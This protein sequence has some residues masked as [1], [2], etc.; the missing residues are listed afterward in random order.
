VGTVFCDA[1]SELQSF[2]VNMCKFALKAAAEPRVDQQIIDPTIRM[3][4]ISLFVSVPYWKSGKRVIA[5]CRL[6]VRGDYCHMCEQEVARDLV[7]G[8]LSS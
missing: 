2:L 3:S 5:E 6:Q 7:L 4:P 1:M 8:G